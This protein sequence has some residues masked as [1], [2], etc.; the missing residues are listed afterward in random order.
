M[1]EKVFDHINELDQPHLKLV[2]MHN[3]MWALIEEL[4]SNRAQTHQARNEDSRCDIW[5]VDSEVHDISQGIIN[6]ALQPSQPMVCEYMIGCY[7]GY[8]ASWFV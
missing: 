5:V 6:Q 3:F 8:L 4:A 1:I 2:V 7:L